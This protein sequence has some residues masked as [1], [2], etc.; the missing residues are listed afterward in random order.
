MWFQPA[1]QNARKI[2]TSL[3]HPSLSRDFK[4]I[5]SKGNERGLP[6]KT[7]YAPSFLL[8]T[9]A[10]GKIISRLTPTPCKLSR[11]WIIFFFFTLLFGTT[12]SLVILA[13]A[14]ARARP[15]TRPERICTCDFICPIARARYAITRANF[16]FFLNLLI[17]SLVFSFSLFSQNSFYKCCL[18]LQ[19]VFIFYLCVSFSSFFFFSFS[20]FL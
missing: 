8:F 2:S 15:H 10:E 17:L 6:S 12:I 13:R 4:E 11:F 5:K 3:F 19:L 1:N 14:I 16:L 9:P 7:H 20:S 18:F